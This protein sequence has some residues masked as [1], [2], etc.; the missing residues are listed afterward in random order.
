MVNASESSPHQVIAKPDRSSR[1]EDLHQLQICRVAALCN[2][3][4]HVGH[5]VEPEGESREQPTDQV[6][7]V[8]TVGDE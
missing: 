2:Q 6:I 3:F 1:F 5:A 4:L 7:A 8:L